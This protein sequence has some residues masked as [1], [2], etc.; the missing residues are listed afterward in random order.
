MMRLKDQDFLSGVMF[1][2]FGVAALATIYF[3]DKLSMGT[4]QRP[5]TGVLPAILAWCLVGT[6]V[7][8]MAKTV[9]VT[10]VPLSGWAWRPLIAVTVA[11]MAFGE[12]I[13]DL[14]LVLTMMLSLT[15]CAAG[16]AETKWMEYSIFLAIMIFGGVATFIWLLGMPIPIWPPKMPSFLSFVLR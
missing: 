7:I 5:G 14:G 6:G 4:A 3:Y 10:S 16:T 11:T 15:I 12:L 2:L 9:V 1:L 8:L 13:D